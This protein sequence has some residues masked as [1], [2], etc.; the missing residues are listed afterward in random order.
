MAASRA[1]GELMLS[2]AL[3][4]VGA[5]L[6]VQLGHDVV[7]DLALQPRRRWWVGRAPWMRMLGAGRHQARRTFSARC[8]SESPSAMSPETSVS[9]STCAT[10]RVLRRDTAVGTHEA[11]GLPDARHA[12]CWRPES[13]C[14]VVCMV[15]CDRIALALGQRPAA[16]VAS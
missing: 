12:F 15:N 6:A 11:R 8:T 14:A 4:T 1:H 10:A 5:E 9:S 3:Y 13:S 16:S 7:D 2:Q